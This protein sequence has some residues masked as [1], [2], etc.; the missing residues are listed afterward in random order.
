MTSTPASETFMLEASGVREGDLVDVESSTDDG[1]FSWAF[2]TNREF[3][4]AM[5]SAGY[6]HSLTV[7]GRKRD[8]FEPSDRILTFAIG[9]ESVDVSFHHERAVRV[10]R[11]A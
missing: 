1:P 5:M 6:P 2:K 10:T 9:S 4:F 7:V 11:P 3:R 8:P